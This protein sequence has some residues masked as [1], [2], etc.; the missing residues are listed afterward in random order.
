MRPASLFSG[1]AFRSAL[2][3]L[4]V[5]AVVLTVAGIA[6][7]RTTEA[8]MTDQLRSS[9]TEDFDLLRDANV[10]GGETELVKFMRAAVATRSDKQ[11][12]FGLFKLSGRKI[13][14]NM[15]LAPT[16]RGWGLLPPEPGQSADNRF[17]GYVEMLDDN[18][19]VAGRSQRFLDTES[20]VILNALILSGLVI[21]LA[22]LGIGYFL[23]RGVSQKLAVIDG[24]LAEVSH[25]NSGAR[26]PVGRSNDQI[27][28]VS[29]QINA[30][31]DRLSEL[32]ANMRNTIV[33]IAH[34]LKSP[35]HRAYMLLQEAA[36][37]PEPRA[38]SSKLR[39]A[40][41]EL[42][43][44][45]GVLDTVLRIS[46]IET[47]NDISG[48]TTFSAAVLMQDLAQTFEPVIEAAGQTL[49]STSVP[50][51]GAA[52]FGD[53]KMVQQMLVNLIENASRHAGPESVI[54]LGVRTD[55]GGTIVTVADSGPGIPPDKREEVFEPFRRLNESRGTPGSGLGL[56]LVKAVATRHH[57]RVTLGDNHPGLRVTVYFPPPPA[58]A[59]GPDRSTMDAPQVADPPRPQVLPEAATN[60]TAK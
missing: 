11:S 41:G 35:M 50:E 55:D 29:R 54:E 17:L 34:D 6:I 14:G 21:C 40:T 33:A 37:E 31:L 43:A 7:L 30:H 5:F 24:T 36:D 51:S 27:D 42:E 59:A 20:G 13:A 4:L 57:A 28:H 2:L 45:G 19:V 56:A 47:S 52:I 38:A 1:V 48:Y 15:S 32:M 9:I 25:G 3:F 18:V 8:S 60:F 46:R 23:N 44:L 58:I 49:R 39:R 53:R 16:F 22:A 10:T 12:E 26:L